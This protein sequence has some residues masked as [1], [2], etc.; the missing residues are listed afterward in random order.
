MDVVDM[1]LNNTNCEIQWP[2]MWIVQKLV[3]C[4]LLDVNMTSKFVPSAGN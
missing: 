4:D 1:N 3:M 2:G